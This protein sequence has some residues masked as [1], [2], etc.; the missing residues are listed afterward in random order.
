MKDTVAQDV[1][2]CG[3]VEVNRI[4]EE[5]ADSIFRI[6][7]RQ[8]VVKIVRIQTGINLEDEGGKFLRNV[9]K[10]YQSTWRLIPESSSFI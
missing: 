9:S 1:M 6:K 7:N 10:L 3:L 8:N 2:P 5:G 4:L